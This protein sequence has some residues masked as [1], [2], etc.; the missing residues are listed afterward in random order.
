MLLADLA[1]LTLPRAG[2]RGREHPAARGVAVGKTGPRAAATPWLSHVVPLLTW[3]QGYRLRPNQDTE[4]ESH[5]FRVHVEQAGVR[6]QLC[7]SAVVLEQITSLLR[8]GWF[9]H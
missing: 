9:V 4:A 2:E 1:K 7:L 6:F 5:G 3:G 8:L